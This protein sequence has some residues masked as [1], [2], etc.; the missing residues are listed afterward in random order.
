VTG[1]MD[2]TDIRSRR[3]GEL[4]T[5]IVIPSR[6]CGPEAIGNG[7]WVAGTIA[8]LAAFAPVQ[9]SLRSPAPLD[10]QLLAVTTRRGVQLWSDD[11]LIA[12]ASQGAA[13][14]EPPRFVTP[15]LAHHARA[16]FA[17]F[18]R[19]P[20]P[21]CFVCGTERNDADGLRILPGPVPGHD[22]LV[23]TD[24][25]PWGPSTD[26]HL[27]EPAAVWAAL[28]CPTGWAH[29][30]AG[31]VALLARLTAT[32]YEPV[33]VGDPHVIVA[34]PGRVEGRKLHASAAIYR[35]DGTLCAA[36]DALWVTIT[37]N[38]ATSARHPPQHE[39]PPYGSAP[40]A[41]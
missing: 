2:T 23:A 38:A 39:P 8:D 24:W 36:A 25:V 20:F 7:G 26:G 13:S 6:Y 11:V 27:V 1:A 32:L 3:S 18:T 10:R 22:A 30:R 12:E 31:G 29:Y 21:T 40:P 28:D 37:A 34:R 9:V 19:H 17:G 41:S 35:S 4:V 33:I 14:A 15:R 5:T 16:G